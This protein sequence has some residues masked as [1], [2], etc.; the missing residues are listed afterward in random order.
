MRIEGNIVK[1]KARWIQPLILGGVI[2]IVL[3]LVLRSAQLGGEDFY[4]CDMEATTG[5]GDYFKSQGRKFS[6][7]IT[8]TD[9]TA[10]AGRHSSK[11]TPEHPY[12]PGIEFKHVNGGDVFE[13]SVWR[14]SSEGYGVLAFQ[15]DWDF[16]TQATLPVQ[17]TNDWEMVKRTLVIPVG[18]VDK[19]IRIFPY[20]PS[21]KGI[22]YFDNL[23]IRYTK[24]GA[25]KQVQPTDYAGPKLNLRVD[26]KDMRRMREKRLEAFAY[27]NLVTS[28]SDLVDAKLDTGGAEIQVEARL[29]GDLLDH[30]QGRKWSFRIIPDEGSNWRGMTEFSV[31]NS[32]SRYHLDEWLFHR[33]IEQENLITTRYDFI[34][35]ALNGEPLGIYA[36]EE[37]FNDNF[38]LHRQLTPG[39]ILRINEDGHW[40]YAPEQWSQH[41][42]WYESAQYEAFD[43]K[44]VLNDPERLKQFGVARDLLYGFLHDSLSAAETFDLEKMATYMAIVDLTNAYHAINFTNIRF[45]F[46]PHTAKLEPIA[47]DGYTD[48]GSKYFQAPVITGSQINTRTPSDFSPSKGDAYLHYKLFNDMEFSREY[49]HQL[50]RVCGEA[51]R[52]SFIEANQS[53]ML[54]RE[55][56]IQR[57]YLEYDFKWDY[58]FR[59]GKEIRE[60]M[61]PLPE[62]S[63]KAYRGA[64][65]LTVESYHQLPIEIIGF[66]GGQLEETLAEPILLESFNRTIPVRRYAV[67]VI[68]RPKNIF[69]RTL[70]TDKVVSFPIFN[71]EAPESRVAAPRTS[72]SDLADFPF[73]RVLAD[74]QIVVQDGQHRITKDLVIPK[75]FTLRA[76]P[77]TILELEQG[78]SIRCYGTAILEGTSESPIQITSTKGSGGGFQL[79]EAGNASLFRHTIFSQLGNAGLSENS[80]S[81]YASDITIDQCYFFKSRSRNGLGIINSTYK[82]LNSKIEEVAGDGIDIDFSQGSITGLEVIKCGKDAIEIS[83]GTATL[84]NITV[85]GAMEAGLNVNRKGLVTIGTLRVKGG[86]QGINCTGESALKIGTLVLQSVKQGIVVFKKEAVYNGA[87]VEVDAWE[88]NAV[89]QLEVVEPGS[90]LRLGDRWIK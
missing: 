88:Q 57:E 89:D 73:L 25:D 86:K 3:L 31:H 45:Y 84:Y 53:E 81:V 82:I 13:A 20:L 26:E 12:G 62:I 8:Q 10:F 66:G 36:Y 42:A 54:G 69:V 44:E 48:D 52:D 58:Y 4:F 56:F 80:V 71:W 32:L 9:E 47:Y 29:K 79:I 67:P 40:L 83:G 76:N 46:N 37:H 15:G 33:L 43:E 38:L 63:I 74:S 18:V 55:A 39:L 61:Y 50:E 19:T 49:I 77:G 5:G 64:Q 2:L 59:N 87:Q 78:A 68:G 28:K 35:M 75:G 11:C 85:E 60:V 17:M 34:E 72:I 65:G 16:Y 90:S 51:Y 70:G 27:G 23:E 30:L 14:N 1:H 6:N 7:G 22:V 41:P 24:G 21:K